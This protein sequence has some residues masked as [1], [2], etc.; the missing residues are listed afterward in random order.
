MNLTQLRA[1]LA[2][3]R[4]RYAYR[5]AREKFWSALHN[6]AGVNKWQKLRLEAK[7]MIHKRL[8][9]IKELQKPSKRITMYD[10]ITVSEIP[11]NP[12]AVAGYVGGK[13]PNYNELLKRFP[14]AHHLSIAVNSSEQAQC[15]DVEPG[16]ATAA[17]VGAWVRRQQTRG[18]KRP[19]IYAS[20]S[21]MPAI[22]TSLARAG[23]PR[24]SVRLW[25]AHYTYK[26]HICTVACGN[27]FK[28]TAD[29]TQWSD[30]A[31]GRNLDE[32]LCSSSFFS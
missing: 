16:D 20:L 25:S 29:A 8:D 31:L 12:E 27:G 9:Q 15:L 13:W 17:E 28:G 19:C 2:L 3:W 4:G 5:L 24:S 22:L 23:I 6:R 7:T 18:V 14:K 21:T 26:A 30:K 10:S 1:S 11:A 32:S